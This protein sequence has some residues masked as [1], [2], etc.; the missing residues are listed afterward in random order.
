[1]VCNNGHTSEAFE[2]SRGVRQGCPLSALLFILVAE[3]MA[4]NIRNNTNIKGIKIKKCCLKITQMADDT[5]IFVKDINSVKLVLNILD[6][7]AKCAGL[8]LNK[9]KLKKFN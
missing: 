8:K 4:A 5:T 2:I 7:F 3:L 1:M 6:H 9:K